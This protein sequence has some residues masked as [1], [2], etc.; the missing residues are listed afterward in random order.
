MT[1][2]DDGFRGCEKKALAHKFVTLHG[3]IK[4]T[5]IQ[6]IAVL[7]S[8]HNKYISITKNVHFAC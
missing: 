3:R 6:R 4:K 8:D 2:G 1:V 7:L 5:D